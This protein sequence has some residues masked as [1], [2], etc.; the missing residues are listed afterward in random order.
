M[1]L[2]EDPLAVLKQEVSSIFD[3]GH[4]DEGSE[5]HTC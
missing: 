3:T 5:L 1:N 4:G 2:S